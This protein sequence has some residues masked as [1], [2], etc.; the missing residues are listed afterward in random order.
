MKEH[1]PLEGQFFTLHLRLLRAA[2]AFLD[3]MLNLGQLEPAQAKLF[4]IRELVLSEPMATQEVDR[5]TFRL[6]GQAT[7]YY[8]GLIKLQA[9]RTQT[10]LMLGNDFDQLSF[11]DFLLAQ[12][13]LPPELLRKAVLE[14]YIPSRRAAA[15]TLR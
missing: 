3:P 5:Y 6:P 15:Q 11:H 8:Y 4:L 2:R 7:S 10:E 14:E 1:L 12:G 9:L 13:L